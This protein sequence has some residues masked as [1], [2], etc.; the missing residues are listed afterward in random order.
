MMWVVVHHLPVLISSYL[1]GDNKSTKNVPA[2]AESNISLALMLKLIIPM[3]GVLLLLDQFLA[4]SGLK[5]VG[6]W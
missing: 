4:P 1:A 3:M 2:T 6:A 5:S